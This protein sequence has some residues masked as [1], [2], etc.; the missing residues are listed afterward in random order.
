MASFVCALL[1]FINQ[2]AGLWV[3]SIVSIVTSYVVMRSEACLFCFSIA[4]LRGGGRVVLCFLLGRVVLRF[5][6]GRV[7]LCFLCLYVSQSTCLSLISFQADMLLRRSDETC[8]SRTLCL[9]TAVHKS[10][11]QCKRISSLYCRLPTSYITERNS[12]E[13]SVCVLLYEMLNYGNSTKYD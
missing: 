5:L 10:T 2:D 6:L 13:F 11:V 12:L 9:R 4:N 7:V 8:A 1:D 3:F